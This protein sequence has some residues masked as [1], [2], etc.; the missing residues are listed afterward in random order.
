MESTNASAGLFASEHSAPNCAEKAG[1]G[2][3]TVVYNE[4]GNC[5][6]GP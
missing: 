2:A 3:W 5:C 4:P 1:G 6:I